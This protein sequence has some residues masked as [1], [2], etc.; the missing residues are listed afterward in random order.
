LI[1][2]VIRDITGRRLTI[3]SLCPGRVI[4]ES[5]DCKEEAC[6]GGNQYGL[7]F[8]EDSQVERQLKQGSKDAGGKFAT[9]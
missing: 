9:G 6:E 2:V 4:F 7:I 5:L 8:T 3:A 1:S